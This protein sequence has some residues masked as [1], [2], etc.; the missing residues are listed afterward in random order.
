ME[1]YTHEQRFKIIK[2]YYESS[3]SVT[4]TLRK[5]TSIF[6]HRNCPNKTTIQ[7]LVTKFETFSLH[8]TVAET[9][10]R[11]L[12]NVEGIAV[13]WQSVSDYPNVSIPHRTQQ[14]RMYTK[15]VLQILRSDLGLRAYK[16]TFTQ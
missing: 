10:Q 6:C 3:G 1:N 11:I 2:V 7:R 5:L 8:D 9:R 16:I 14:L 4:V 13:V 15:T 12:R